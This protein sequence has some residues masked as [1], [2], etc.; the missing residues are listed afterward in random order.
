[1]NGAISLDYKDSLNGSKL[2]AKV[3]RVGSQIDKLDAHWVTEMS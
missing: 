1:M 2:K 3:L